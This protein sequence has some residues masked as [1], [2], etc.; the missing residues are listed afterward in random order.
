LI[1][2]QMSYQYK[3]IDAVR[4]GQYDA[5]E[6]LLVDMEAKAREK[7][8]AAETETFK[9][10]GLLSHMEQVALAVSTVD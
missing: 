9:L 1:E 8:E 6:R 5:R 3:G 10:R 2:E 4:E 7:A